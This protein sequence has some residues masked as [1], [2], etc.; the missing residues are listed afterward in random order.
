[1][2]SHETLGIIADGVNPFLGLL[3]L[4]LPYAKWRG[5]RGL[6][7]RHIA[8]TLMMVAL[9]Y[10][11]RAAL[12]LEALWAQWG[13]DF[14]THGAICIVLSVALASLSWPRA[15][16]WGLAFMSYDCLMV[17]QGYHTWADIGTTTVVMLPF[18][19]LIRYYGDRCAGLVD[20]AAPSVS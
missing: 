19:K 6:A 20:S 8:I 16:I 15:W 7:A 11:V 9:T 17:Y 13:M 1:V 12:G 14:S 4:M 10:S 3:A 2:L 5:R 18:A